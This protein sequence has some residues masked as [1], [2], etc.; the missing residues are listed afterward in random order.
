M[1]FVSNKV[2]AC[3]LLAL[4]L[5]LTG[6]L[7]EDKDEEVLKITSQPASVTAA[8]G[9]SVTFSV[10]AT[11]PG[12]IRY[13]WILTD[14]SVS[15]TLSDTTSTIK[16]EVSEGLVGT[17]MTVV[18]SNANTTIISNPASITVTFTAGDTLT[19]GAQGYTGAGSVID[20]DS[21]KVWNSATAN[22][23]QAKIDLVY[24]YY[25][26]KATL[27]GAKAARDSGIQYSINLTNTYNAA[28]V[29]DIKLVKVTAKPASLAIADSLYNAG[30]KLRSTA[31]AAGDKFVVLSSEDV[32]TYVEVRSLVGT[33]A[34]TAGLSI[35]YGALRE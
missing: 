33:T 18:V 32:L 30:T 3:S 1:R 11:G 9:D 17:S 20:L 13:K 35:S 21:G 14:G 6:C 2:F 4:S 19:L 16:G 31:V 8:L 12:P 24:L 25:N 7:T 29:K 34:G 10:T 27:N 22:A 5:G 28:L 15:D 26:S 23:N